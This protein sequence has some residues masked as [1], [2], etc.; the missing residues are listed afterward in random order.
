V[1]SARV[2][3]DSL[4]A[5]REHLRGAE[6]GRSDVF[7]VA[8]ADA[9]PGWLGSLVRAAAGVEVP[10]VVEAVAPEGLAGE[11]LDGWEIGIATAALLAGAADVTGIAP[12][13]LARVR[14]VDAALAAAD[15]TAASA[16]PSS[17]PV[18]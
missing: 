1:V 7:V 15:A 14:E 9:V 10:V 13:R 3:I 5:G 11:A 12:Q 8:V 18:P 16:A 6:A 2:R 17:E 4:E